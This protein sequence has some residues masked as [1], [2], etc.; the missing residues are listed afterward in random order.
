MM[1][2]WRVAARLLVATACVSLTYAQVADWPSE[3]PPAPLAAREVNFPPFSVRTLTNGLEVVAV[4]H[5]EQPA[6]TMRLL[7]RVGAAQDPD[8]RAGLAGQVAHLL[9]QGTTSRSA[10]EIADQIDSI[11]GA[12]GTGSGS[13]LTSISAVVMKDSF[14]VAM[15]LVGDVVRNPAFAPDEIDRQLE[16]AISSL[17][18]SQEDPG[19]VASVL[20]DRLVYGFHPYGRAGGSS[21]SLTRIT[22]DDLRTFHEQ[23][24]VPN[25]MIL[26]IV[27]DV[28]ADE[29]FAAA[30]RVFGAWPRQDV[31]AWT[32]V[33]PPAPTRRVVVVDKPDAVQTEIRVGQLAIPRKHRDYLPFDVAVKILGGEGANRLHRVLRSERGLTYG[34]EADT[35]ALKFAGSFVAETNTRTET[36]AETLRLAVDEF[37]KIQRQPVFPRELADVQAYLMGSFPLTIE[38]PNDIATTV[39]NAVFYELPIEE[40]GTYRERVRRVTP[41]DIQR[42]AR[43]YIQ[44]DRLS[45]VL[46]GDAAAF[47]AQLRAA[48]F[49]EFDV[50]PIAQLDLTS[51]TLRKARGQAP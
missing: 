41:A 44:P 28:V 25:N 3:R 30:E 24:F 20:F 10:Q 34:A 35:Q 1:R 12:L 4:A 49:P 40:V 14:A 17:Q 37:A 31:P 22:R 45:I 23:Y 47:S 8:G 7:V 15:D 33:D 42:V 9:D 26:A 51:P 46:V 13:D 19:Y 18:V 11:G 50:I 39:I 43:L 32:P 48:G 27:G 5:H 2:V 6:V 36:T 16:Q 21:E 29:A 38:T